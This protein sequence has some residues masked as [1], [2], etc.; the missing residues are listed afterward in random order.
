MYRYSPDYIQKAI[1]LRNQG[2]TYSEIAKQIPVSKSTLSYW[3]KSI[4]LTDKQIEIISQ[5]RLAASKKGGNI[6]KTQRLKTIEDIK[7][8]AKK[9][10]TSISTKEL[11]LMGIMLYWAEGSK[12]K[13]NRPG[14]SLIFS[15]SDPNMIKLYLI[16]LEKTLKIQSDRIIFE[17]YIHEKLSRNLPKIIE[18]WST[19]TSY[20]IKKFDKIYF[21]RHIIK[22]TRK[23][24]NPEYNGLIR[25]RV[26]K[27]TNLNRQVS[28]WI[29]TIYD[30]CQVV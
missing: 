4:I 13:P 10:I 6:R 1:N 18:Y 14:Q 27:S 7:S 26:T 24:Y 19:I 29:D 16:W 11:W 5:K 23:I 17:I 12:A 9:S 20:P 21:K 30:C 28:A 2:L 15:N 8:E 25:I 22:N 3:L